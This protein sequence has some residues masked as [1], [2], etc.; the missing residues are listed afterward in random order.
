METTYD[1]KYDIKYVRIKKGKI[2][3]TKEEHDWL[4]LDCDQNGD[5][6]GIEILDASIH[7]VN[8]PVLLSKFAK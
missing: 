2:A 5:I 6:L 3:Q 8:I 1:K 4:L 7:E